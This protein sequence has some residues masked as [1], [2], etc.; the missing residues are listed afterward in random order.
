VYL[1]NLF[2]QFL[3]I[4]IPFPYPNRI[5]Y[6]ALAVDNKKLRMFST[7]LRLQ[8]NTV[9][10]S[11][12]IRIE[13][14]S[15]TKKYENIYSRSVVVITHIYFYFHKQESK[16]N[17]AH[18]NEWVFISHTALCYVMLCYAPLLLDNSQPKCS[19]CPHQRQDPR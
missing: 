15:K 16:Q 8:Y 6:T 5:S 2:G 7:F 19:R 18:S 11:N 1:R 12:F 3:K 10:I 17:K 4:R 13:Y 9:V 14:E